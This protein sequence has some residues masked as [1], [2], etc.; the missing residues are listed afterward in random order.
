MRYA[1]PQICFA[2]KI[3]LVRN[4]DHSVHQTK[5]SCDLSRSRQKRN[6]AIHFP[7][8]SAFHRRTAVRFVYLLSVGYEESLHDAAS[9]LRI[10]GPFDK[11]VCNK[12]GNGVANEN[13]YAASDSGNNGRAD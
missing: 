10:F 2:R 9:G 11:S 1:L 5:S 7:F 4:A 3:A 13:R 12:K 6:D 8:Y